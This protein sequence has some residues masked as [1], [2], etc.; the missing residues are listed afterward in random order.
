M[1]R[2]TKNSLSAERKRGLS[3]SETFEDA[4]AVRL[5]GG[6]IT[7][8]PVVDCGADFSGTNEHITYAASDELSGASLSFLI[9]FTPDFAFDD[10][11]SHYMF[12]TTSEDYRFY[13]TSTSQLQITIGNALI[14]NMNIAADWVEGQENILVITS[15]TTDTS[16]WLNGSQIL[17]NDNSAWSEQTISNLYIGAASNGAAEYEGKISEIKIF[18]TQLKDAEAQQLSAANWTSYR[19]LAAIELPMDLLRHDATNTRATDIS[20]NGLHGTLTG[21]SIAKNTDKTGYLLP[22]TDEFLD[23]GDTSQNLKTVALLCYPLTTT[24]DI[25]DLDG[26]THTIEVTSGTVTATGFASPTIYVEGEETDVLA[27]GRYQLVVVTTDTAIDANDLDIGRVA[28]SYFPGNVARFAGWTIALTPMQVQDLAIR[29]KKQLN[30][31]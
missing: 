27:N 8:T 15:V 1:S 6:T 25:I 4:Q 18:K 12:S 2:L 22:G 5:N 29:V 11:L 13:K 28:A 7:G 16:V 19:N 24:A 10:G 23:V 14:A 26:G 3:F 20:G 30:D 17:T 9:R 21:T 31:I